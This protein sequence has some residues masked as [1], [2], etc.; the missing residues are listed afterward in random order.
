MRFNKRGRS[1]HDPLL[2]VARWPIIVIFGAVLV[3]A[4]VCYLGPHLSQLDPKLL[5]RGH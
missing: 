4:I 5:A 1:G 2:R 3:A